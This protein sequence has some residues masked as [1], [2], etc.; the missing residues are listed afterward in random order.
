VKS[1]PDGKRSQKFLKRATTIVT[2]NIDLE[3]SHALSYE[4]DDKIRQLLCNICKNVLFKPKVCS[5]CQVASCKICL[6][7][8]GKH[9]PRCPTGCVE[10]HY[11]KPTKSLKKI[12]KRLKV[13][14]ENNRNGCNKVIK[15]NK[16][17][18]HHNSCKY[19]I[20]H[21]K[22][23]GCE[24][25]VLR[26]DIDEHGRECQYKKNLCNGCNDVVSRGQLKNHNC[27][28]NF[29]NRLQYIENLAK[30]TAA[31]LERPNDR[32]NDEEEKGPL[33]VRHEYIQDYSLEFSVYHQAVNHYQITLPANNLPMSHDARCLILRVVVH[34]CAIASLFSKCCIKQVGENQGINLSNHI[35]SQKG[36]PLI[37]ETMLPWSKDHEQKISIEWTKSLIP[38]HLPNHQMTQQTMQQ[39]YLYTNPH[40][41]T[42]RSQSSNGMNTLAPA[43]LADSFAPQQQP[44]PIPNK[45]DLTHGII[46]IGISGYME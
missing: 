35:L 16:V 36:V 18:D 19:A 27:F 5:S 2:S 21:C 3:H 11:K 25:V 42:L 6:E 22:N 39:Q 23:Q 17:E 15:Y 33:C 12:L 4:T 37:F 28:N 10:F 1:L 13:K 20:I 41:D 7:D 24:I 29:N 8:W 34:D 44:S 38:Q 45:E 26:E 9:H 43:S 30:G 31:K 14:C 40:N 32:S 46:Y